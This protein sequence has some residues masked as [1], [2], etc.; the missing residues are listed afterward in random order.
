MRIQKTGC[1]VLDELQG[2]S[3]EVGSNYETKKPENSAYP[4]FS[5][6]VIVDRS[7]WSEFRRCA[8]LS[9]DNAFTTEAHI[10]SS[11]LMSEL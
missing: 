1:A 2:E 10:R 5:P 3:D 4:G 8:L 6:K 9:H 7:I 11:A